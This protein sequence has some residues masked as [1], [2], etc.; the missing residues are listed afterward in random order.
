MLFSAILEANYL[1]SILYKLSVDSRR[2]R[3]PL[4][5]ISSHGLFEPVRKPSVF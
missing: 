1:Y 5:S 3:T 2:K 4:Q